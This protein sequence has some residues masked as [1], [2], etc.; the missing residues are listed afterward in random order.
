VK[1]RIKG[2]SFKSP[3]LFLWH[4][5]A[6]AAPRLNADPPLLQKKLKPDG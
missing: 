2:Q 1:P 3:V 4:A 5:A 6:D